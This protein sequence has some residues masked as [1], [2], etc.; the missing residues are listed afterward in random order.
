MARPRMI[1]PKM[2]EN[3]GFNNLDYPERV[4]WIGLI[5]N[6]DDLGRGRGDVQTLKNKVF[7]YD[8]ISVKKL[9][10]W[11][12]NLKKTMKSVR[13]YRVKGDEYYQ[14]V[15]W[16]RYQYIRKDRARTSDLPQPPVNQASTKRQPPAKTEEKRRERE[17]KEGIVNQQSHDNSLNNFYKKGKEDLMEGKHWR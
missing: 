8:K 14:L 9:E 2:W 12:K 1:N 15:H 7:P 16:E 6:A 11:L 3:H 4:L 5:S 17:E 13:F 10:K